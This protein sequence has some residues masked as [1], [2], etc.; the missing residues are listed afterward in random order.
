MSAGSRVAT[1]GR[2]A[3]L[4]LAP[5]LLAGCGWR[6]LDSLPLPG[7]VGTGPDS[8]AVTVE[9]P[10]VSTV[11]ENSP[12]HVD[13]V[14]VG[15]VD[16]IGL[17]DGH[18]VVTLRLEARV[19][20]PENAVASIG[21]TSLLGSA[22]VELASPTAE[23]ARGRL[24]DGAVIGLDRAG[25]YPTTEETL[26]ALSLVLQGGGLARVGDIVG[27]VDAALGGREDAVRSVLD[28][29]D[30]VLAGL[31]RHRAQIDSAVVELDRFAAVVAAD[32]AGVD[33]ALAVFAP[34]TEVLADQRENLVAFS[35]ALG[36]LGTTASAV[37]DDTTE[38]LTA[39]LT[40][41]RPVLAS[42]ADAGDSLTESFRYLLTYPF[43]IDVYRNAVRGDYA[44]GEVTLDLRLD[45]LDNAL[46]LGTPLQGMLAGP[47]GAVGR[48]APWPA[49]SVPTAQDLLLPPA[50][51]TPGGTP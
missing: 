24:A 11:R 51:P 3:A 6:G 19:V 30:V 22:H 20:L 41:L 50:P 26:S 7:T 18:A 40:D 28:D 31:D 29:L 23:P 35:V 32:D 38:D 8:W 43:P 46:L 48:A 2:V 33:E 49:P 15:H 25:A 12:V 42:L 44:N 1:V 4:V 47:E 13:D 9:M 45:T 34:A 14:T 21:Q 36:R 37:T 10:N 27:E 39:V 5:L 17:V 16:R